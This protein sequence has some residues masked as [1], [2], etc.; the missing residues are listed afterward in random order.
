VWLLLAS[1]VG[2]VLLGPGVNLEWSA[3]PGCP[4]QAEVLADVDR[5]L[6][7]RRLD[8]EAAVRAAIAA[9]ADGYAATVAIDRA[10]ART[11]RAR[12]CVALARAVALVIAVAV[13]PVAIVERIAAAE[14]PPGLPAIVPAPAI[15]EPPEIAAPVIFGGPGSRT[16]SPNVLAPGVDR[17]PAER[18]AIVDRQASATRPH[19]SH[20]LTVRGGPLL[21]ATPLAT[22][23]VALGYSLDRGLLRIEARALYGA[24]RRLEYPDGVGARLQSLTIGAL[25]C[26]APGVV[27]VRFPQCLGVEA[28]PLI[29]RGVGAAAPRLRVDLWAS[30]LVSTGLVAR[31]HPRVA[32]A[33]AVE[34][35]VALRRPAFHVG[36]REV[37]VRAPAVGARALVGLEFVL[38]RP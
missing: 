35:A 8:V 2:G 18:A 37:L 10:P 32:V 33:V 36:D 13:D 22:G 12:E 16:V 25:A 1:L 23:A 20:A 26:V 38:S 11:L 31:V 24:P 5:L 6:G 28:G 17:E 3:P 21:G 14:A 9:E 27:R 29:G 34:F 7:G 19:N 15:V 4:A 30:G